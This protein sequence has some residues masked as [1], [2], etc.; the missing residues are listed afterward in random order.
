MDADIEHKVNVC[1]T[2]QASRPESPQAPVHHWERTRTPWSRLHVDFAGP[3]QG[4]VF[5]IFVDSFSKWLEVVPVSSM[6]SSTV[7]RCLRRLFAT[8][9]LPDIIVSNNAAQCVSDELRQFLVGGLIHHVTSAPFHPA[10]NVQ[11]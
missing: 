2:C 4:Q 10:T 9:G 5:F 8:H 6:A 11:A 7:I 1:G 3:F